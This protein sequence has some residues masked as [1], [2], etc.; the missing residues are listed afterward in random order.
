MSEHPDRER[1]H[2]WLEG[3]LNEAESLEIDA[4]LGT[5]PAVCPALLEDLYYETISAGQASSGTG[6]ETAGHF[7][8]IA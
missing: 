7:R 6:Q 3:R 8:M 4:H 1:L 5:C 2:L